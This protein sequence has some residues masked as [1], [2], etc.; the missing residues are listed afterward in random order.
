MVIK[1]KKWEKKKRQETKKPLIIVVDVYLNEVDINKCY[2]HIYT[3]RWVSFCY[4]KKKLILKQNMT[5]EEQKKY[6]NHLYFGDL[7]PRLDKNHK[8]VNKNN[9]R[10]QHKIVLKKMNMSKYVE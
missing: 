10:K 1:T 5:T 7:L 4:N 2:E 3:S 9:T 8:K 6:V